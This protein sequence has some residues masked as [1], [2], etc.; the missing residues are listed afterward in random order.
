MYQTLECTFKGPNAISKSYWST[1][2]RV[3]NNK[4]I[5]KIQ[6][7]KRRSCFKFLRKGWPLFQIL[8]LSVSISIWMIKR[9]FIALPLRL[10]FQSILNTGVFQKTGKRLILIH[11][12]KKKAKIWLK[13]YRPIS[14]FTIFTASLVF[15]QAIHLCHNY[16][17]LLLKFTKNWLVPSSGATLN[18]FQCFF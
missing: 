9:Y 14:F 17:Q 5:P 1:S 12:I 6:P 18:N 8:L 2:N 4:K 15:C 3:L 10:F 16:R 13:S 11:V 7:V